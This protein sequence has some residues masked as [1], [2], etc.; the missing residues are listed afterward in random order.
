MNFLKKINLFN[1]GFL[2]IISIT[3]ICS[4]LS[5]QTHMIIIFNLLM[6]IFALFHKMNIIL[7][8][9]NPTI[10]QNNEILFQ[11]NDFQIKFDSQNIS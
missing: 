1:I 7:D 6:N 3:P 8:S 2:P 4:S 5:F 10:W 11:I 9:N